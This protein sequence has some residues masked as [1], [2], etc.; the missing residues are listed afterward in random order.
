MVQRLSKITKKQTNKN[1][2]MKT[3][4]KYLY[5]LS[6]LIMLTSCKHKPEHAS[7]S[8]SEN[9]FCISDTMMNMIAF[10][11]VAMEPINNEIS[12][13]GKISFD[14]NRV[15][16]VFPNSSGQVEEVK[17][18]LGDFV[19]KGQPLAI[20]KSADIAGDYSDLSSAA[21][22]V[23]I[24]KRELDNSESLY[25]SGISSEREYTVAKQNY[26]KAQSAY[27][28]IKQTIAING[29][30]N[31]SAGG[32]FIIKAPQ[33]GYIVEKNVTAGSFIRSDMSNNLFTI[34]DLKDVWVWAN[35][36]E[37]DIPKVKVGYDARIST[38]AYNKTYQG[39]VNEISQVL[40]PDSKAL[41]AKIILQN[42]DLSLKP[43][44]F[45]NVLV[46]N[47]ESRKA[48]AIPSN[49]VIF[50]NGKNFVVVYKDKCNLQVK[51]IDIMKAMSKYTYLN[52]GL[53]A[54][55]IVISKN[56]LLLYSALTD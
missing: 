15:V 28:K 56:A 29:G 30:G 10:D 33:S 50:E 45:A 18:S 7:V 19:S 3:S 48:L 55:E 2:L 21:S 17:V 24:A 42:T 34:S 25:K 37:G 43:D 5:I 38:L 49:S 9:K 13:S 32:T 39:K 36:F 6:I 35:V 4:I 52:G 8:T 44:M 27:L 40:D 16:K 1:L 22:D 14:E 46:S 23:A 26:D 41:R 31:T 12:L 11:T 20:L 47:V 53:Q 54:G 51:E